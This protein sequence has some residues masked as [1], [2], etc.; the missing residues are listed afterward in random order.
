MPFIYTFVFFKLAISVESF[1][2]SAEW[3]LRLLSIKVME[4]QCE[5][6]CFTLSKSFLFIYLFYFLLSAFTVPKNAMI[7]FFF[8]F[9]VTSG[10]WEVVQYGCWNPIPPL[11]SSVTLGKLLSLFTP[12]L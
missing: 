5:R 1:D 7:F 4:S 6:A 9:K 10:P 3:S 11:L 2:I 12:L 8:K